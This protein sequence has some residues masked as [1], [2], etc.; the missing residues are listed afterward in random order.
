[1]VPLQDVVETIFLSDSLFKV[2]A[3]TDSFEAALEQLAQGD[4]PGMMTLLQ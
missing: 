2:R 3:R 4:P 1:M